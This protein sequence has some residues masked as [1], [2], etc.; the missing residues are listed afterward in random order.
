L[1]VSAQQTKA[2][3]AEEVEEV[4]ERKMRKMRKRPCPCEPPPRRKQRRPM[5]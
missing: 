3:E 5:R 1:S 4:E 2:D